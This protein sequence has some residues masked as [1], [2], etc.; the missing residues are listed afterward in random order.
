M[1][2]SVLYEPCCLL[3]DAVSLKASADGC[4]QELRNGKLLF[5]E[6]EFQFCKRRVRGSV[7]GLGLTILIKMVRAGNVMLCVF[8]FLRY[9]NKIN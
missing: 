4:C 6:V 8:S 2:A 1:P 3:F 9:R 5:N 7:I